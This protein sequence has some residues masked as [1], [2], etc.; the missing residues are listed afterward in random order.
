MVRCVEEL[1]G[2][3]L[4]IN[5]AG[6]AGPQALEKIT[7]KDWDEIIDTN[8]KSVFLVTQAE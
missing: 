5:N 3:S 7:E 4:L 1:G 6:F 2:G 8:L